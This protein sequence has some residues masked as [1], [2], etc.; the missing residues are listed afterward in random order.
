MVAIPTKNICNSSLP[1]NIA[2]DKEKL[3]NTK[4]EALRLVCRETD[5]FSSH[6]FRPLPTQRLFN[7]ILWKRGELL[8][9]KTRARIKNGVVGRRGNKT[10]TTPNKTKNQPKE[11]YSIFVIAFFI[12]F[13]I[14]CAM[15]EKFLLKEKTGALQLKY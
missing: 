4:M 13:V 11:I 14:S 10:P 5:F 6:C 3:I 2:M 7:S 1:A 8:A 9:N 15:L 12:I